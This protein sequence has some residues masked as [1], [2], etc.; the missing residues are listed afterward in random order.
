MG[1]NTRRAVDSRYL[2][3]TFDGEGV[4]LTFAPPFAVAI[5]QHSRRQEPCRRVKLVL[6]NNGVDSSIAGGTLTARITDRPA[7]E[8]QS[9]LKAIDTAIEVY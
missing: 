1:R 3:I 7:L 6:K 5:G 9:L 4:S 8:L 2:S